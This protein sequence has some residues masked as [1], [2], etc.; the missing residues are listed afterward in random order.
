MYNLKLTKKEIES[1]L[2]K[3]PLPFD[4]KH[5]QLTLKWVLKLKPNADDM[6]RVAALAHDID[7]AVT[8]ITETYSLKKGDN[9]ENFKKKHAKRSANIISDLL[10]K[11]NYPKESIKKIK[12]L[13]E[14]HEEGGDK[15]T[16]ILMEADSIAFFEYNLERY[17]KKNKTDKAKNKI[18]FMYKRLSPKSRNIIRNMKFKDNAIYNLVQN[19]ISKII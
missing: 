2:I 8:G 18:R 19:T 10:Q 9:L 17:L 11:H 12:H 7:R 5:A 13:V 6:L 1:I 15:E 4:L 3:S 16:N 14:K